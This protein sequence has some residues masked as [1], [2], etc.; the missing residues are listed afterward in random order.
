MS[1]PSHITPAELRKLAK[2]KRDVPGELVVQLARVGLPAPVRELTFAAS[3]KRK[4]R[5]DLAWPEHMLAVECDGATFANG[6]HTRGKGYEDDCVKFANA[7]ILGWRVIR[8][9]T[10]MVD[11]GRARV[12][13]ERAFG[14]EKEAAA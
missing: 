9:T 1:K 6:R 14:H 5:F 13:I 8:V 12:F 4:W 10:E 11:D 3:I 7:A 2:A